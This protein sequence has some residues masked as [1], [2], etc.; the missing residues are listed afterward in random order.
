MKNKTFKKGA[1]VMHKIF[2]AGVVLEAAP[3]FYVVQFDILETPRFIA[4]S[5]IYQ[6]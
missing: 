5:F 3:L 1:K 2:G 6:E 4:R